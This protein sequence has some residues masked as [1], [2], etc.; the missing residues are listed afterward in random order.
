MP[1]N[2][3]IKTGKTNCYCAFCKTPRRIYRK[4]N[5]SGMNILGSA[6][7]ATLFMFGIWQG[8]D[9][10]VIIVFVVFLAIS[11]SFVKIR[12]RLSLVCGICGFDPILY[13][14][15]A[16]SASKKVKMRLDERK[17]DPQ[18]LLSKPL[19]LPAISAEKSKALESKAKGQLVSR[20]I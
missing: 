3:E 5:I 14:K 20:S 15:D 4:K 10:R 16:E 17:G 19:N 12:W 6:M 9:P 13:L 7:A 18:Y 8:F 11:E 2:F 1:E